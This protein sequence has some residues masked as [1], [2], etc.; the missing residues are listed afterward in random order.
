MPI[1]KEPLDTSRLEA[2]S[3]GVMAIIITITVFEIKVPQ[4]D[5]LSA[6]APLLPIFLTYVLSFQVIGTYWNNHH[7]LFRATREVSTG[8]MWANLHLLFWLSLIPLTSSWLG[9]NH[10]GALPTALYSFIL[11]MCA[12]AY[13]VLQNTIIA[14]EGDNS[15]LAKVIGDDR[16]GRLSLVFYALAIAF[17][18]YNPIISDVLLFFVA[19]MWFVPDRRIQ[20]ILGR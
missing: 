10:G 17:A 18:F 2:F 15:A 9:E 14:H 16:K 1:Q 4:G 13:Y 8:I 5:A 20:K 7:H 19:L 12:V 11:F 3:D 6:L